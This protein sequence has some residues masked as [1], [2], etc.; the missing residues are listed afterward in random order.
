MDGEQRRSS[1]NLPVCFPFPAGKGARARHS[2][3]RRKI[4]L[5]GNAAAGSFQDEAGSGGAP[6][7]GQSGKPR[8]QGNP[9]MRGA[10][11][12]GKCRDAGSPGQGNAGMRGAPES[13]K[14][15]DEGSPGIGEI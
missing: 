13:G 7:S 2:Q 14:S 15:R 9:G 10:P 1:L 11:G 8:D 4:G 5:E 6:G 3:E 12:A